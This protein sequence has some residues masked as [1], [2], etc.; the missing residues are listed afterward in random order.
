M[1]YNI[2]QDTWKKAKGEITSILASRA[3]TRSMI[4]YTELV[5]E[6]RT[7]S[8]QPDSPALWEMLGDVSIEEDAANRGMLSVLV[9]HKQGDMQPGKGLF[10]LAAQL[11]RDTSDR[12]KCWMDELRR[13]WRAHQP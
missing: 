13:V 10:E 2:P 8:L 11:G 5:H 6:I 4:T 1:R 9:V 7:I 3:S 12:L